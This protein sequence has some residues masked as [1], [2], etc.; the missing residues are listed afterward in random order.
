MEMRVART[1]SHQLAGLALLAII[2]LATILR[3]GL[4]DVP[5]ERDKGEYAY[6]GQLILQCLPIYHHLYSMKL[7][8]IYL[9]YAANLTLYG[10][11]HAAIHLGFQS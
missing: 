6:G 4:L 7:P 10:Q 3:I 2:I 8:G 5:L 1:K 11:S 9:A